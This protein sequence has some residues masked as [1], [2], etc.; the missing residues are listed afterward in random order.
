MAEATKIITPR[1][2]GGALWGVPTTTVAS[3]PLC[4][5]GDSL[6]M[7]VATTDAT[8]VLAINGRQLLLNGEQVDFSRELT[9]TGT[10]TLADTVQTLGDGWI[11]GF[12]VSKISGTWAAG[13][14]QAAVHVGRGQGVGLRKMMCLASGDIDD[15]KSLGLGAF[16]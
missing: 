12:D 15:I 9:F 5:A 14:V 6:I 10:G 1:D 3:G 2:G 7:S 8:G 4:Q 11:V 13:E 16:T